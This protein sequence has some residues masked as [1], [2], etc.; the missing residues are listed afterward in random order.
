MWPEENMGPFGP[1]DSHFQLPG[2]VGFDCH[3]E[4]QTEQKKSLAKKLVP[5]VLSTP[6]SSERHEV[7]LAHFTGDYF[8]SVMMVT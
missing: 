7:I 6:S 4:G 3:L 8:V 2:N 5:K 1:L